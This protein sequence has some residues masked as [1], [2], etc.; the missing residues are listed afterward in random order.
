MKLTIVSGSQRADSQSLQVAHYLSTLAN[1]EF[2]EID[3]LDLHQLNL[4]LWNEGVWSGS[5]EWAPWRELAQQLR[6]SDAFIFIT[7][8][9]HGMATPALKNFLMLSTA[10]EMAHKPALAVSVSASVNGVYPISELRLTGSK[11]NHVCFLPDHLIFR[12]VESLLN[13]DGS[14]NDES[15]QMR[16]EYT[17]KLLSAYAHALKPIHR[18]MLEAGKPFLYGM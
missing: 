2:A 12:N 17:I 15:F 18:D 8:E 11:N 16:S 5:E 13:K 14:V 4:P 10:Q 6:S 7:P 1:S 9:W 3:I